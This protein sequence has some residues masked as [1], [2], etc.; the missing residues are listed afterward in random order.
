M[1]QKIRAKLAEIERETGVRILCAV[2]S[3]SR[4]W[5]FASPDSDYDVRFVYVRPMEDYL[6]LEGVR[7]VI[8]WQLDDVYD[9]SGWDLQK[10]LRLLHKSNPTIFE[11]RNSPIRYWMTDEW[12][13]VCKVIDGYFQPRPCLH[14]YL[15]MAKKNRAAYIRPE[16]VKLKKYFYVLRPLLACLW[17]MHRS[18]PPPMLFDDLC[19]AEL[20]D[21]IRPQVE[22]LLAKKKVTSEMG[23]QPPIPEL[24]EYID[25]TIAEVE[26][27]L[28][29]PYEHEIIDWKPLNE[30]FL[31]FLNK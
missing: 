4:A 24:N 5:G 9:V 23:E 1:E 26:A 21:S 20:E 29:Q 31:Q 10:M 13:D 25:R 22:E 3:G 18:C 8:E 27:Y 28:N 19:A 2:E 11:W 14:H 15:S 17:I 30:L 12:Q 16:G 7:D 6:K